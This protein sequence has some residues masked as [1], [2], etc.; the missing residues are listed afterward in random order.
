MQIKMPCSHLEISEKEW[1]EW[2]LEMQHVMMFVEERFSRKV[3]SDLKKGEEEREGMI[4]LKIKGHLIWLSNFIVLSG[5]GDLTYIHLNSKTLVV[6]KFLMHVS[7]GVLA[8][9]SEQ[10]ILKNTG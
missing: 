9:T 10:L 2:G 8:G 3:W 6:L 5:L 4:K 7:L 1:S